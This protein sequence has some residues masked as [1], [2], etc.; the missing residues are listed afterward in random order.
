MFV[1]VF[2]SA[3]LEDTPNKNTY[4]YNFPNSINLKDKYIA[5]SSV[6]LYYSWFNI[7]DTMA[8]NVFSYTWTVGST[9]TTYNVL[10][11]NGLYELS[12][13]NSYM[14]FVM[15]QNGHYLID[16][17]GDNVYYVELLV[18][19]NRYKFQLNTFLVP[20]SLPTGFTQ[21]SSFAG[22][23][24]VGFNPVVTFPANF[25]KIMGFDAGFS[26]DLNLANGFTPPH[27]L[28]SNNYVKKLT[29][30]TLSYLSNLSP[31]IQPNNSIFL[32]LNNVNNPYSQPSSVIYSI[33]PSVAIGEQI[34]ET[35]PN[36]SWT[37]LIDGT[38]N[39]L[40]VQ[41]LGLDFG[42]LTLNDPSI[43]VILTI[44]DKDEIT[45]S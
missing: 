20:T 30:G 35:P 11:P 16:A 18:N 29:D 33:T 41:F 21:P 15:E 24:T 40:R 43:T 34:I 39:Q 38:Y 3:N 42:A 37:K 6:S 32:S 44:K 19:P 13:I 25:N 9:S 28:P 4:V 26:S 36:F 45:I 2:T 27:P 7:T 12:D 31:N 14:Q 17:S 22:Y 1:I 8:N 5:V 10:I 23:P